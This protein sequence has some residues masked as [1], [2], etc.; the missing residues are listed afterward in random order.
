MPL[1]DWKF[2]L[3]MTSP[4]GLIRGVHRFSP[5]FSEVKP[6][7]ERLHRGPRAYPFAWVPC[8]ACGGTG[9]SCQVCW[10]WGVLYGRVDSRPPALAARREPWSD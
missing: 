6:L 10:G 1:H 9:E 2:P 8:D 7:N 5:T 4:D 3:A